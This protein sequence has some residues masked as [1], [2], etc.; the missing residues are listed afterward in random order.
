MKSIKRAAGLALA[1]LLSLPFM[2]AFASGGAL[3]AGFPGYMELDPPIVVNLARTRGSKYLRADI[4]LYIESNEEADLVTLHM[5]RVRDRLISLLAGR[6]GSTLMTT[7]ARE[8][9]RGELL[10]DLREV[11]MTQAGRPAISGLYFTGF[12][13]Q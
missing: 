6:D 5:P 8:T 9:L 1:A 7:E 2:G 3:D 4:Q 12:I 11:M 13:I 10:T